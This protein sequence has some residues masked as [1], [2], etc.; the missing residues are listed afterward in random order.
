MARV[1]QEQM[2]TGYGIDMAAAA[3]LRLEHAAPGAVIAWAVEEFGR[4]LTFGTGFGVE[5]MAL[6]D[7]AVKVAPDIDVFFLDTE[8]LFPE[9]YELRL[10]VEQRYGIEIRACHAALAPE[11]QD[12]LFGPRLWSRDPDLCCRLRKVGPLREALKGRAAWMTAIRRDQTAIRASAIAVEWDSRWRLVKVN[13]LASWTRR[14]VWNYIAKNNVP[15][16]PLLDEGYASIGCTHCTRPV[17][18]GEQERAGRWPG[19]AKTECG[20]HGPGE[21]VVLQ[22][23]QA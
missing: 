21:L 15:Y 16:N 4:G 6:L 12:E 10:R 18:A 11:S 3:A 22:P 2:S 7:M 5:G 1:S 14:E 17:R 13:P 23:A 19:H 8:F 20:L 9:T